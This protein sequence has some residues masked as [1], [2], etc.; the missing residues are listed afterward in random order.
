MFYVNAYHFSWLLLLGDH[1]WSVLLNHFFVNQACTQHALTWC[2]SS[3]LPFRGLGFTLGELVF[4]LVSFYGASWKLPMYIPLASFSKPTWILATFLTLSIPC[5]I[6]LR[7]VDR[8]L[9]SYIPSSRDNSSTLGRLSSISP[10]PIEIFPSIVVHF[11]S[12]SSP[13]NYYGTL[14]LKLLLNKGSR[15][16]MSC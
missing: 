9:V 5:P 1:V 6:I 4:I 2:M 8:L 14:A 12:N 15:L 11:L 16:V 7:F 10:P 13:L 3:S